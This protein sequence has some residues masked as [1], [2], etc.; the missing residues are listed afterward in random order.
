MVQKHKF[1]LKKKKNF[2]NIIYT[3]VNCH[4]EIRFLNKEE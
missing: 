4:Q 2:L 1:S 3:M